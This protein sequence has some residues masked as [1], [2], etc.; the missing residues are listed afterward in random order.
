MALQSEN[1]WWPHVNEVQSQPVILEREPV[2]QRQNLCAPII[3]DAG[4]SLKTHQ[5]LRLLNGGGAVRMETMIISPL[6]EY[7][8][9]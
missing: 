4:Y 5:V 2:L 1:R 9:T 3:D 6:S 8:T 7:L